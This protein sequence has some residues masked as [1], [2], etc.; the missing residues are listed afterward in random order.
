M[1][2]RQRTVAEEDQPVHDGACVVVVALNGKDDRPDLTTLR[3][4][5]MTSAQGVSYDAGMWRESEP[6]NFRTSQLML[7]FRP[8]LIHY[9]CSLCFSCL[10]TPRTDKDFQPLDYALVE[11]VS[12]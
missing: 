10:E 4:F 2:K 1:G 7:D 5:V 3:A 11:A 6:H 9:R 12:K 8:L